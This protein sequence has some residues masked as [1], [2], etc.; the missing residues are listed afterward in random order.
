MAVEMVSSQP[1][2]QETWGPGRPGSAHVALRAEA[3]GGT[4]TRSLDSWLSQSQNPTWVPR[5]EMREAQPL[6]SGATRKH[7]CG[8]SHGGPVGDFPVEAASTL[9]ASG[10]PRLRLL[11]QLQ[12]GP[13]CILPA[14][15][16][17]ASVSAGGE[18]EGMPFTQGTQYKH[19]SWPLSTES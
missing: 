10:D 13:G 7:Q 17:V 8:S 12:R 1:H 11:L 9:A 14:L 4:R 6:P 16:P 19:N 5:T 3:K 15:P 18:C 2:R